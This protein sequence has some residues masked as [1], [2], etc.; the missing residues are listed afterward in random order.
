MG[1]VLWL[2]CWRK[3]A[4]CCRA[5]LILRDKP[6]R[7]RQV[8]VGFLETS[9]GEQCCRSLSFRW[10]LAREGRRQGADLVIGV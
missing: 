2:T 7:V 5:A 9:L 8:Y 4:S 6:A 10:R 3:R 1:T